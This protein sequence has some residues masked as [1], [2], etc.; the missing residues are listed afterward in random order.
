MAFSRV[1][2]LA[3]LLLACMVATAPHAEAAI[4]C[5]T[6]VTRLTP[7]LTF[8]RSGGA[9]APAC[10]NGVKA[11]NNDAKTTPDRQAA[12]GCLKTASTSI[13]GIQ[14][15]NAASLAGKCGVNLPY[16]ISPTI[17]CSKVK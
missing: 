5:G 13:S 4:T 17:D 2:K 15:G 9:V 12:C 3:C 7:C 16:K 10:C 1:A 8:L 11:L 6:V 14:L